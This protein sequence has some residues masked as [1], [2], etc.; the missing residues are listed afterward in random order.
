[1]ALTHAQLFVMSQIGQLTD[2]AW[3]YADHV[4]N[5]ADETVDGLFGEEDGD[6]LEFYFG[7]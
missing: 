4:A 7:G 1:M 6:D 5:Q 2:R 3:L